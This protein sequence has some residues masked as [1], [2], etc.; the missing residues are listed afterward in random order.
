MTTK[1]S[2]SSQGKRT[3]RSAGGAV[4]SRRCPVQPS[5]WLLLCLCLCVLVNL[6][7]LSMQMAFA[8]Q[9]GEIPEEHTYDDWDPE[10]V[11][12]LNV[13]FSPLEVW[14]EDGYVY[15]KTQLV[16]DGISAFYGYQ[17]QVEMDRSYDIE[18]E[19]L[20]GGMP[21]ATTQKD[22]YL[23]LAV[24]STELQ[25]GDIAVC[26]ITCKFPLADLNKD[27]YLVVSSIQVV[28]NLGAELIIGL[29]PEP[30]AAVLSLPV[31]EASQIPLQGP[32]QTELPFWV[33]LLIAL[34]ILVV[35]ILTIYLTKRWMQK[36]YAKAPVNQ[37]EQRKV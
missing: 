32:P 22:D 13:S 19:N 1:K 11:E 35:I 36:K 37:F 27:K 23:Y 28:T 14:R 25:R 31:L 8:D 9:E 18:I 15:Y 26:D 7:P 24:I 21:T 10:I 20:A 30:P 3:Y 5:A 6:V 2:L 17:I 29:G 4:C 16:V 33:Y 12:Q 34:G